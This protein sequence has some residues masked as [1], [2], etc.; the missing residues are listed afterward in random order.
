ML[1]V[2]CSSIMLVELYSS[3]LVKAEAFSR[4]IVAAAFSHTILLRLAPPSDSHVCDCALKLCCLC[5]SPC[6]PPCPLPRPVTTTCVMCAP[7]A[8]ASCPPSPSPQQSAA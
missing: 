6:P 7:T 1:G 8:A 3:G 4:G 5:C 2:L